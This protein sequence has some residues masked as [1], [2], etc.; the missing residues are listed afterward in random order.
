[1]LHMLP[2]D[3]LCK[4]VYFTHMLPIDVLCNNNLLFMQLFFYFRLER[5]GEEAKSIWHSV[6][7]PNFGTICQH[8]AIF[9]HL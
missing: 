8:L 9:T 2:I 6:Q 7:H 4:I 1:M 3:V 5:M